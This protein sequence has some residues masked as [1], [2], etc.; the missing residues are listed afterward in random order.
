MI[1]FNFVDESANREQTAKTLNNVAVEYFKL[2]LQSVSY[3][4]LDGLYHAMENSLDKYKDLM[5]VISC[6]LVYML[7]QNSNYDE[8]Y[9]VCRQGIRCCF[10]TNEISAMPEL[11]LQIAILSMHLGNTQKAKYFFT[12]GK[13]VFQWSRHTYMNYS[14]EEIMQQNFLIYYS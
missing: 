4:I 1:N 13:D 14:F 8:A 12:L 7:R 6:N 10:D 9:M 3:Q 5:P 11:I 2:G